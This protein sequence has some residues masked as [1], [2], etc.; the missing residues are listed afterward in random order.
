MYL[1]PDIFAFMARRNSDPLEAD[2]ENADRMR[3]LCTRL[4]MQTDLASAGR[5]LIETGREVL[6]AKIV[7]CFLYDPDAETLTPADA[8]ESEKWTYSAASG[9][10]AFVA[11]TGSGFVWI[12]WGRILATIPTS[13]RRRR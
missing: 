6:D 3:D 11:R 13:M 1:G 7:Q 10:A 4:P 2:S 9:L 12:V 8:S 5:L